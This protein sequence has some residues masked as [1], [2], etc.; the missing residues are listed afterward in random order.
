MGAFS[1][2]QLT[3]DG[4]EF[5]MKNGYSSGTT[6]D[7]IALT[8]VGGCGIVIATGGHYGNSGYDAFRVSV[9]QFSPGQNFSD[10]HNESTSSFGSWSFSWSSADGGTL[11]CTKNAGTYA[12]GGPLSVSVISY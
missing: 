8:G 2:E 10:I 5:R 12:G 11:T 4:G 3:F 6:T 1:N 9:F 7:T